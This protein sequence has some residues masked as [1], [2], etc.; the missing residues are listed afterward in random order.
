[1]K[2]KRLVA[3][4]PAYNALRTIAD[5]VFRTKLYINEIIVYNDGSTVNTEKQLNKLERP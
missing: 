4:I 1:M 3:L 2:T 5:V